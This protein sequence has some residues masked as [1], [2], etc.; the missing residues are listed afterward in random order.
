MK[1]RTE[2]DAQKDAIVLEAIKSNP[3]RQEQVVDAWL[4]KEYGEDT[5]SRRSSRNEDDDYEGG[6]YGGY[7]D[8]SADGI[9]KLVHTMRALKG[10]ERE[11]GGSKKSGFDFEGLAEVA[12]QIFGGFLQS[13]Q[14]AQPVAALPNGYRA[15]ASGAPPE[16]APVARPRVAASQAAPAVAAGPE[17]AELP[18]PSGMPVEPGSPASGSNLGL[19]DDEEVGVPDDDPDLINI[20][21]F[22]SGE[23]ANNQAARRM[24]ALATVT[25]VAVN[26]TDVVMGLFQAWAG[27]PAFGVFFKPLLA[28]EVHARALIVTLRSL[29]RQTIGVEQPAGPPAGPEPEPVAES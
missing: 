5:D 16:I 21:R 24:G 6:Y 26:P 4:R 8:D 9:G 29:C 19:A 15:G 18:G 14:M 2:I 25:T 27:D 22:L 3:D 12:M 17:T 13:R 28:D 20:W 7:E 11:F 1:Q 23:L 10:L